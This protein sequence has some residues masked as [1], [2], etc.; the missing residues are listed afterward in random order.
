M[1]KQVIPIKYR[2]EEQVFNS[3]VSFGLKRFELYM[4]IYGKPDL[5]HAHNCFLA[6]VLAMEIKKKFDAPYVITEHS[7]FF[8]GQ[9]SLHQ[10]SLLRDVFFNANQYTCVSEALR[11]RIL[12]HLGQKVLDK[13]IKILP[14]AIDSIFEK[15]D[16]LKS[17]KSRYNNEFVFINIGNLVEVKNQEL[18]IR[19]FHMA[20]TGA[21]NVKLNI[22]ASSALCI[23]CSNSL[24]IK[25]LV[26]PIIRR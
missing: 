20:Y 17:N 11:D 14:N 8:Y 25:L 3:L 15:V 10:I 21:L 23:G 24:K 6:G 18:L 12:K 7:S 5:I 16:I 2:N 19:S 9:L 13:E 22:T 26:Q 1:K 4:K